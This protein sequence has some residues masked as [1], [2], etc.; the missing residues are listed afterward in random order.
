M[1]KCSNCGKSVEN[2]ASFCYFC[3]E[4][5]TINKT[6][7][8]S[9]KKG[10]V[11]GLSLLILIVIGG[12]GFSYY[13]NKTVESSVASL[14][15]SNQALNKNVT[16]DKLEKITKEV[17]QVIKPRTK[18]RLKK[19]TTI[20]AQMLSVVETSKEVMNDEN[21]LNEEATSKQLN[22]IKENLEKVKS[23]S[24]TFYKDH[25][26]R[27]TIAQEQLELQT[28][29]NKKIEAAYNDG[30]VKKGT[31]R[32]AYEEIVSTNKKIMNETIKEKILFKLAEI[33]KEV[34]RAEEAARK[35]IA[36]LS[37]DE[38]T[39]RVLA[40][41]FNKS[42]IIDDSSKIKFFV[43]PNSSF[44]DGSIM[45]YNPGAGMGMVKGSYKLA[46]NGDFQLTVAPYDELDTQYNG[47]IF[48]DVSQEMIDAIPKYAASSFIGNW[49]YE[50]LFIMITEEDFAIGYQESDNF[51]Y[52]EITEKIF[53]K[54]TD[55]LSLKIV[56]TPDL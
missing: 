31:T 37:S 19:D 12:F 52:G 11:I 38:I 55:T 20:A 30:S 32:D 39:K 35:N 53:D 26:A 2:N 50:N 40:H 23:F 42:G 6:V 27:Y 21:I 9:K 22:H 14:F 8:K 46:D 36:N 29:I 24:L 45:Y 34:L 54:N 51:I 7:K 1:K 33:E 28:N 41:Y 25:L 56:E 47:N 18:K 43:E 3:G 17:N 15:D 5:Q 48:D 44:N 10:L 4:K 13:Q 16:G 49:E